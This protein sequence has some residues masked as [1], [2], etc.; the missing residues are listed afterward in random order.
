[1]YDLDVTDYLSEATRRAKR[2]PSRAP[3]AENALI[4]KPLIEP[5]AVRLPKDLGTILTRIR[6]RIIRRKAGG[7]PDTVV[8]NE[9]LERI[10]T[11][12]LSLLKQPSPSDIRREQ[13][14]PLPLRNTR[15]PVAAA[16]E[17]RAP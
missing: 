10:L 2:I 14:R 17:G 3:G 16:A 15:G 12:L 6:A 4:E 5:W 9:E 8:R 7:Y 1:M 11:L 13:H